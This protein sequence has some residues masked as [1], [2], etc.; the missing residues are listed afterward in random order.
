MR[1]S[2]PSGGAWGASRDG[3]QT[4][5]ARA[6]SAAA[7]F[8]PRLIGDHQV[9]AAFALNAVEPGAQ[10]TRN[11]LPGP[12]QLV[13]LEG[14]AHGQDDLQL[15]ALRRLQFSVQLFVGFIEQLAPLRVPD[16]QVMAPSRQHLRRNLT[17]ERSLVFP[18]RVLCAD[19]DRGTAKQVRDLPE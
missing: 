5:G 10:L 11:A 17:G 14:L 12:S 13:L 19:L 2:A 6:G 16:Q 8:P 3:S 9:A 18:R 1:I 7:A 4:P 15:V